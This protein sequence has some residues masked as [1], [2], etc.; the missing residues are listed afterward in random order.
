MSR[1]FRYLFRVIVPFWKF[2]YEQL[3]SSPVLCLLMFP[4]ISISASI[5]LKSV[6]PKMSLR[7]CSEWIVPDIITRTLFCS[8][9]SLSFCARFIET[10]LAIIVSSFENF[11]LKSPVWDFSLSILFTDM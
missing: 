5:T 9:S 4:G 11:L 3:L 7:T 1:I 8:I 2:A 10:M 6:S